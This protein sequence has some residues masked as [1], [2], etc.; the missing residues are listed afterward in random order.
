MDSIA[1]IPLTAIQHASYEQVTTPY[2]LPTT[3]YGPASK[4]MRKP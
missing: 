4:N 2:G 3:P 1:S